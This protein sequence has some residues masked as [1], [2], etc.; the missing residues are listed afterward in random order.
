MHAY[1][2]NL[3]PST[4]GFDRLLTTLNEFE[5]LFE[6]KKPSTY[7]P[8]NIVKFNDD[9]YQIQIAV[10]GFDKDE[11]EIEYKNNQ[12]TVNGAIKS[13]YTSDVEFL[14]HGLA[15]RDFSHSFKLSDIVVVKGA[16]I[17]N[18]VLKIDLENIYP[19]EK[20]PRKIPI[21]DEP[22][23]TSEKK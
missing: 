6:Q 19:E 21:G 23:L 16:D 9:N 10:A 13:A 20:K 3:L 11:I 22:L 2:R 7:P 17:V 8:Y 15:S 4:V 14:H 18:G 5:E 1:G 12:L